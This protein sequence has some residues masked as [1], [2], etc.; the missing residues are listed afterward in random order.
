MDAERNDAKMLRELFASLHKRRSP[1]ADADLQSAIDV[2]LSLR[3]ENTRKMYARLLREWGEFL[4]ERRKNLATAADIDA[5]AWVARIGRRRGSRS[6]RTQETGVTRATLRLYATIVSRFYADLLSAGIVAHNP[7]KGLKAT[8]G[9]SRTGEKRPTEIVDSNDAL[10][11]LNS[12]SPLTRDGIRDRAFLALLFG[13]GLRLSEAV[14]LRVGDVREAVVGTETGAELLL[15]ATKSGH[16]QTQALPKWAADRVFQLVRQR[17]KNGAADDDFLLCLYQRDRI[18]APIL[19]RTA[20]E[21]FKRLGRAVGLPAT[22]TPHSARATAATRLIERG[23]DYR[24]VA[25]FLRHSG[26]A[27]V[28]VYDKRAFGGRNSPAQLLDYEPK[29]T[30]DPAACDACSGEMKQ[31]TPFGRK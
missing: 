1:D 8:L 2:F 7:F 10:T 14:G 12:P 3:A 29:S 18:V 4:R 28:G 27:M 22:I 20:R 24:S 5:A 30:E 16:T 17:R 15:R 25:E 6:R 26:I 13:G 31:K 23:L 9:K 21:L 11:L 19:P